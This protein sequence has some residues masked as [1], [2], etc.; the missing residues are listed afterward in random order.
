MTKRLYTAEKV[1]EAVMED[2][3][4][5]TRTMI[6]PMNRS[7]DEFS[8]GELDEDETDAQ[9]DL[10]PPRSPLPLSPSTPAPPSPPSTWTSTL[11]YFLD[12]AA[13]T[14]NFSFAG[15]QLLIEGSFYYFEATPLGDIDTIDLTDF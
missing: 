14:I 10:P 8:D 6:T 15:V 9:V 3:W 11:P 4:T 1:L 2:M 12:H 5:M 7:D 13:A